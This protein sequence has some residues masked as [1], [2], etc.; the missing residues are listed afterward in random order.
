MNNPVR[1]GKNRSSPPFDLVT[2]DELG[3]SHSALS[4]R[5]KRGA[6]VRRYPGV[7]SRGNGELSREARWMAAVLACGEGAALDDLSA[8]ALFECSRWREEKPHAI[9][10]RRHR[11]IAGITIHHGRD[12]DVVERGG[13][14]VVTVARMLVD[15]GATLTAHQLAWVINE[16]AFRRRFSLPATLRAMERANGHRGVGVLK[17]A[18]ELFAAGSAGTKSA[19]EDAFLALPLPE[20]LV[21]MEHLGYE[22]DFRWPE[23]KVV[24]EVD[25]NHTRPKDHR[26]D[27]ARDERLR[28]D[29]YTVLRF[30]EPELPG[31]VSRLA[32]LLRATRLRAARPLTRSR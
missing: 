16:A 9:V 21:N 15:L 29:G 8:A 27:R 26:N 4:K 1:T 31:A 2:A 13:I 5:V 11:A 25:G 28:A 30:A 20:P 10:P 23:A 6:L 18:I 17:R 22:V 32:P 24:V 14:P 3:L 19:L 7:Y 12:F